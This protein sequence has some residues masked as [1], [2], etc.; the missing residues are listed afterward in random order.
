MKS[1]LYSILAT[2]LF[3]SNA[4]AECPETMPYD[5]LMDCIVI[6][7]AG[8]TYINNEEA[9]ASAEDRAREAGASEN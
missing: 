4:Y 3:A 9:G 7:G 1:I 2:L 8:E 5:N 6:E